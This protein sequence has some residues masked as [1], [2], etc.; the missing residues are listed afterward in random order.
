[1]T[2][3]TG[4]LGGG[5]SGLTF[6]SLVSG[7]EVLE[8]ETIAGG[9]MRS[10]KEDG[11]TFDLGSHIIFSK[12][13]ETLGF[14][15]GLL[16]QNVITHRRN[17]K[18]FYKGT[19]V[20]YPFENGL[21]DLPKQEAME[22]FDDYKAA[23]E[24]RENGELVPPRNFKEWMHYRFGKAITEK[25]LYPY[26]KKIWDYPPEKMDIFWVEGRVPQPPLEDVRKA[27]MGQE[28]EGYTHQLNFYYP[29]KGGMQA[30]TDALV[31]KIGNRLKTGFEAKKVRRED[32]KWVVEGPETR[33]YDRLVTTMHINDFIKIYDGVPKEV[34]EAAG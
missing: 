23:Y 8:K 34:K 13:K 31:N 18:I 6:A 15:L 28:S 3:K 30:V 33:V 21:G 10:V 17:T 20:K 27:A 5:I 32:G 16:G 25:Y 14:M 4:V 9:L 7:A 1:M 19:K 22:C 26:N 12:N 24:K 29:A 2:G 11:Y